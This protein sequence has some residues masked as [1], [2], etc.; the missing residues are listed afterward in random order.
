MNQN[1]QRL[2]FS[3]GSG[4]WT[5][6]QDFYDKLDQEFNFTLD[7]CC[8]PGTAKCK[9]YYTES[10]D[11]LSKSWGGHTVFMNPPYGRGIKH[12]IRK[13]YEESLKPDTVVVILIPS[14]TDTK[15]WHDY[16]MKASSIRFVKGRLKFGNSRNSAPFPS[17]VLVFGEKSMPT[18]ST[19]N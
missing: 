8:T 5:T 1:T 17:V 15:Y 13:A 2:M 9:N 6:P 16:C 7:P 14:R 11:G 4:N 3:S 19:I 18:I 10:D 12:W